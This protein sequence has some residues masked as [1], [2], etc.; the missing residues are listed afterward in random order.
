MIAVSRCGL[1]PM[2]FL[3]RWLWDHLGIAFSHGFLLH[4]LRRS[5]TKVLDTRGF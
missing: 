1:Y 3:G 5:A 2:E 4:E